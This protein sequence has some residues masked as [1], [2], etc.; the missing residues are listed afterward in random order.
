MEFLEHSD[1]RI[2]VVGI[3]FHLGE[4]LNK[5]VMTGDVGV[6]VRACVC[7]YIARCTVVASNREHMAHTLNAIH[8][9][10]LRFNGAIDFASSHYHITSHLKL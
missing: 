7:V 6:C 5:K 1:L 8:I 10:N 4:A 9:V 3:A 2:Y